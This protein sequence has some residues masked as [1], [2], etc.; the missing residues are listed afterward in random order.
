[1]FLGFFFFPFLAWL[2]MTRTQEFYLFSISAAQVTWR[3]AGNMSNFASGGA[4]RCKW[5]AKVVVGLREAAGFG[6][7]AGTTLEAGARVKITASSDAGGVGQVSAAVCRQRCSRLVFHSLLFTLI[8]LI[9]LKYT[10]CL[11]L[12]QIYII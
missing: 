10:V 5:V 3:L 6:F 11:S 4:A 7:C 1:M 12:I 9:I 2:E 8:V